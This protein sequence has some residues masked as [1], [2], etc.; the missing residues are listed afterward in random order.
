MPV[1][2]LT[3]LLLLFTLLPAWIPSTAPAPVQTIRAMYVADVIALDS[4]AA[5][6]QRAV[7]GQLPERVLHKRFRLVR[8]AYKQTE[9]LT[10][11]L[12]PFS[13]RQLNGPPVPEG[14][15]EGGA[16][17]QI[18]PEGFQVV[19]EMLFPYDP[20]RQ[21]DVLKQLVNIRQT[22]RLL[23][24]VG[25]S[26]QLTDSKLF[27]ALRLQLFR[28]ITLGISG[29]DS[30]VDRQSLPEAAVT[31]RTIRRVLA[32]YPVAEANPEL[33]TE[34]NSL[35]NLAEKCL[36]RSS[37]DRFD[38]LDFIRTVANPLGEALAEAQ[39]TLQIPVVTGRRML[40]T[41]ARTLSDSGIFD[42]YVFAPVGS[43]KPTPDRI[44]LGRMLFEST[45]LSDNS[46]SLTSRSCASCHQ[47]ER[48]FTDGQA[49]TLALGSAHDRI[50][51]N[52][53]T[54]LHAGLQGFQFLDARSLTIEEQI[55]DVLNNPREMG[56]S[57]PAAIRAIKADPAVMALFRRA[58]G[59]QAVSRETVSNAVAHYVRSLARFD[60]CFDRYMR[61]DP[62]AQLTSTEQLGFN[63]FM[64][65][66]KCGT[67][68]FYPI[69][70]GTVPPD[71]KRTE[72]EV[73]GVPATVEE[74]SVSPDSG[75][76]GVTRLAI[77][78]RAFKIPGLRHVALT[79]PYMHNG[80]YRTLEQVIDFY[81]KGG[82]NGLGFM[83][84]NQ[85]LPDQKL[86]LTPR[87]KQ[88][89]IAF[90]HTLSY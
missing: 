14:E 73:I 89:L 2:I 43:P 42:P 39:K 59:E 1:K 4:A 51:R 50:K 32:Q 53:P 81:D 15:L 12:Y 75:R 83:L 36:R 18:D 80:V 9:W 68:H 26:A 30:P 11:A 37:F 22:I 57:W 63:L 76:Y 56:G 79:A 88:A 38:R 84:P 13:A 54:L 60:T 33:V 69:F 21:P 61:H 64:G 35:L 74:R 19:E 31:I 28:I 62:T 5:S 87:E 90:L 49:T 65:K 34:I 24:Q 16:G 55:H 48:A 86:A 10:E 72:S 25:T 20:A 52:T 29:F 67:C 40:A 78:L 82:G 71:Y 41:S 66:A 45:L 46:R 70:N 58:Y 17:R 47:P 7:S 8:L 44:A 6:L 23:W 3:T 85:T 77:H 27:D